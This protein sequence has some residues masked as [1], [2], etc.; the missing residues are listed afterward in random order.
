MKLFNVKHIFSVLSEAN[1]LNVKQPYQDVSLVGYIEQFADNVPDEVMGQ[2]IKKM[3]K[4]LVADD[5]YLFAVRQLPQNAPDWA[6]QAMNNRDLVAFVPNAQLTDNIENVT[7][8]LSAAYQNSKQTEDNN[9][10]VAAER[11]LKAFVK[12]GTIDGMFER[13]N[14]YFNNVGSAKD[15][16]NPNRSHDMKEIYNVGGGFVWYLLRS[17]EDYKRE[18]QLMKN[19]IGSIWTKEKTDKSGQAIIILRKN[20]SNAN[21]G[22]SIVAARINNAENEVLEMKGKNNQVPIDKYMPPVLAFINK[23]KLTLNRGGASDFAR[24]GYFYIDGEFV[25]KEEAVKRVLSPPQPFAKMGKYEIRKTEIPEG[26]PNEIVRL[27][28][29]AYPQAQE[30]GKLVYLTEGDT[31][32][33]TAVISDHLLKSVSVRSAT[34]SDMRVNEDVEHMDTKK[35]LKIQFIDRLIELGVVKDLAPSMKKMLLWKENM[36]VGDQ[37]NKIVPAVPSETSRGDKQSFGW[38]MFTDKKMINQITS[39]AAIQHSDRKSYESDYS[40]T[41]SYNDVTV[42]PDDV[43]AVYVNTPQ[44]RDGGAGD[45]RLGLTNETIVMFIL[46]DGMMKLLR[47]VIKNDHKLGSVSAEEVVARPSKYY[48]RSANTNRRTKLVNSIVQ[49]ANKHGV[50]IPDTSAMYAG[51]IRD[52]NGKIAQFKPNVE[53]LSDPSGK[54]VDLS[55]VPDEHYIAALFATLK[56]AGARTFHTVEDDDLA[57][58]L[59]FSS[60][61]DLENKIAKAAEKIRTETQSEEDKQKQHELSSWTLRRYVKFNEMRE[62]KTVDSAEIARRIFGVNRPNAIYMTTVDYGTQ[63]KKFEIVMLVRDGKII[64]VD[65]NTSAQTWQGWDDYDKVADHLNK[66]ADKNNLRFMAN[67]FSSASKYELRVVG[68]R[69]S[70]ETA[71]QAKQADKL[72]QQGSIGREGT[73]ELP[74]SDGSRW[75]RMPK[76]E[77]QQWSRVDNKFKIRGSV[78]KLVMTKGGQT[79]VPFIVDVKDDN[80][81]GIFHHGWRGHKQLH[82]Q[83]DGLPN[84]SGGVQMHSHLKLIIAQ[85]IKQAMDTFGWGRPRAV[86]A[87]GDKRLGKVLVK[88]LGSKP[89]IHVR[90]DLWDSRGRTQS[91]HTDIFQLH[92]AEKLGFVEKNPGPVRRTYEIAITPS[93]RQAIQQQKQNGYIDFLELAKPAAVQPGWEKPEPEPLPEPEPRAEKAPR[94]QTQQARTPRGGTKA[95]Q[96]LQWFSEFTA[97]NGRIPRRSEFIQQMQQDPFNMSAAGAQTYYY[98]TKK[99]YSAQQNESL[100]PSAL[101]LITEAKISPFGM[102]FISGRP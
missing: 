2:F 66:F 33:F 12:V 3:Q 65:Q 52:E 29:T 101:N 100:N 20:V 90:D 28:V 19:C 67:S 73:D 56:V 39:M 76:A 92:A 85:Y 42:E 75:V 96:A 25:G 5:R 50:S 63:G 69:V 68:G 86:K 83:A 34:I 102:F 17:P 77:V 84:V 88:K 87:F 79:F 1:V 44:H 99:K 23:F 9:V 64:R 21:Q 14:A 6:V 82:G 81:V 37:T 93:G 15:T 61:F 80:I 55:K 94:A 59:V 22:E 47:V 8:Y 54:K 58:S 46:K 41:A 31:I 62:G 57:Q 26:L 32:L 51:L 35:P 45:D 18:G 95:G 10:R 36:T 27:I 38:S 78:W 40:F 70:T 48:R 72:E 24:A 98:N 89:S 4:L 97:D 7:H 16:K 30:G 49:I 60:G 11:E 91:Q 74:F 71:K 53:K 13:A 43:K